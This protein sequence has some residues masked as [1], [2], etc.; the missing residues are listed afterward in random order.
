MF[1]AEGE[2]AQ[3]ELIHVPLSCVTLDRPLP[4]THQAQL[5]ALIKLQCGTL[6]GWPVECAHLPSASQ[7]RLPTRLLQ[8]GA[9]C[10]GMYS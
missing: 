6:L 10:T 5:C 2:D 9:I 3:V 8:A 7:S 1:R 4:I